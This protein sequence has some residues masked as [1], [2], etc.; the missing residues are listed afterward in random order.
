[1]VRTARPGDVRHDL[2]QIERV[3]YV[4]QAN[5]DNLAPI[6]GRSPAEQE[7]VAWLAALRLTG[8]RV[9]RVLL[10]GESV[11]ATALKHAAA[12]LAG[13]RA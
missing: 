13:A 9:A 4:K 12:L 6:D 2:A 10:A 5:P 8:H 1:M 3:D 7:R 11:P